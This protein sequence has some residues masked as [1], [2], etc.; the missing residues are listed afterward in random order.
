MAKVQRTWMYLEPIFSSE[1][2][3]QQLPTE[4]PLFLTVDQL[5]KK[6]MNEILAEPGIMDLV[7]RENIKTN[8]D[9]AFETLEKITKSLN[10]YLELKRGVFPRFYFLA[11]TDL[12]LILA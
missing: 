3:T 2:I 11:D 4:G 5:W 8:F 6:T 12:L 9:L 1:D 7:E 10:D